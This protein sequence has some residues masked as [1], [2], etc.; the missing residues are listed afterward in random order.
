MSDEQPDRFAA[1]DSITIVRERVEAQRTQI[2]AEIKKFE[3]EIRRL[4]S[5][6]SRRRF[7]LEQIDVLTGQQVGGMSAQPLHSIGKRLLQT[8]KSQRVRTSVRQGSAPVTK[9]HA[10]KKKPRT[11]KASR[12]S[13]RKA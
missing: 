5:E 2:E 12:K 13:P 4:E 11:K 8:A 7:A 3:D 9:R 6:I 1:R 10:V